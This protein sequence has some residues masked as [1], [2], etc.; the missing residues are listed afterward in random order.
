MWTRGWS[1][2]G[3]CHERCYSEPHSATLEGGFS[4]WWQGHGLAQQL[5]FHV[6]FSILLLSVFIWSPQPVM[7][8]FIGI[9]EVMETAC[10][11]FL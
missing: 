8:Q 10:I 2:S 6:N 9:K 4:A 3:L 11:P 5:V 7:L 1:W